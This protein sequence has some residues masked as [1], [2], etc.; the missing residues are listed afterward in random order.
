MAANLTGQVRNIAEV[1][2]AVAK[3]DLSKKITVDVKGELLELKSTINTMVDQLN[4][5]ASEVSRVAKEVGTEGK[6]G[7]QARVP[8]V[9]GTWK[10]LTD[11]VNAMAGNL[12]GQV[13]NIAEVTTAVAKGDL[14]KKITV[15]VRG[16]I[17][18][19]KSTFNTMVDQLNA[20]ASEVSRVA[21]E[22]GTEGKLGGQA[23]VVGVGGTWKDLTDNVNFMAA[24]LTGQ[25]R[26]IAEVTTAVAKGDLSKKITVDVKGELLE[27]KSTVNTMVDQLNAFASEVSRVAR[28]VGT[29]GKLGGQARVP[30]V[31]G[32]WKDLTDNVNAMAANVTGQVRNIAEVTTAVA[33][34]DLSKKITVDVKG[35]I[36]ELKSTMNTMVDQ[37]N[38]FASEVS[39]VAREVGSEGKLGG[40]A[41]VTG[42]GGTWKDLTDNVNAMAANLTGQVRNI[43]EVTTAV[44]RGDLSKKITVD[45]RGEIL[46]LKSTF[47][48]MV[49]QLNAFA[50][51]V[52]RVA[53]E[54]GSE[55]RLGGQAEVKGVAGV[56]KGLTDNVNAMAAN[57][58][59]QVR[60][61]AE[62]TTAV[63][64]GDLSKKITVDVRGEILELKNTINRMVDQLNAFAGEVS[65]VAREVGSEGKLGG[66]AQVSGVGGVWKDLT[67]NVN[68]MAANLTGQVRNIAEV[69]TAV[70]KGDLSKK[71]TVD[72]RGEI[73]EL[74]STINT[75]VDQLN[76]F[77]G[78]VSRVA[79]EVGTE[80][81]LGG[82]A[83][84]TGVG[85]T[86]KDLTDNVNFM[87][88]NLTNQVRGIAQVVTAVARGDLKR[89]V[90]FEAKGEIAALSD[91]I[92]G[93]ID[94]LATFADQVTNVA[95]EV[96]I[97]GKLGGQAKV[98]GAAGLWRDLTDNVNQLAANL[99]DQVRAIAEVA[100]AVTKGDL[101]RSVTVEAQ[102][103][104][105]VLKDNI[106]EMIR[107]LKD[108]TL[109]NTEQDWL[110]TNLAKFTRMVQGHRDLFAVSRLVLS[111]LAP[112]VHA[113]QG[114][115]YMRTTRGSEPCL[116]LLASYAH[117]PTK[118]LPRILR[119]G[120][121]LV[122]QCAYE[123]KRILLD[124]LPHDYVRI[125]SVLGSAKPMSVIVLPVLFEGQVKAVIEL[126]SIRQF[127]DTHLSF[128]DQL[129]EGIGIVFN[130]IEANMRTEDLLKQSQSLTT[131]LQSQ[132]E[133][134]KKTNDR[135]EQQ[136]DNLQK[137]ESLLMK[138]QGELQGANEELQE[139]ASMLS[140]QM[141]E[142]A[143]KNAEVE[144]AKAALEEKAEQLALSSRYKSE[145]LANMSHEIRTPLNSLLILARML[146]DNPEN[147]LS[148]KQIEYART[149]HAA[150][151][152]LLS[153]INDILDLAKVESG[154]VT[155]NIGTEHFSELCE[156]VDRT[157][158]QI[159]HDKGL[160]F[161]V[162][163][164][165]SLPP[166]LQTDIKRLQQILKNL[167][168]N[169]CK[170][171]ERGEVSLR[172]APARTGWTPGNPA[173]DDA[174]DVVA[175]AVVDTGVGI[176]EHKQRIIFEAFQQADGT[177][178]RQY[179]G[180]GLG[181]SISREL[182]RLLG[183]ELRVS[184]A[185]GKGSTFTLYLPL[186]HVPQLEDRPSEQEARQPAP[187]PTGAAGT[188]AGKPG[189]L[190]AQPAVED[191]RNEVQAGDRVVLIIEDDVRFAGVLLELARENGFKAVVA[192][193]A[194]GGVEL[195]KELLP[196]AILLDLKLPDMDGWAVLDLLKHD[197]Q[198][199]HIPV[200]VI[201]VDEGLQK[202]FHMGA[203]GATQKPVTKETLEDV[204]AKTREFIDR[205]VKT[206]LI[207][208]SD[209]SQRQ[210]LAGALA[211]VEVVAAS[212]GREVLAI[213][214]RDR[215]DCLMMGPTLT[216]MSAVE[217]LKRISRLDQAA[218]VP[219]VMQA[220]SGFSRGDQDNLRRL[221][222][223]IV[224]KQVTT[225]EAVLEETTLFLHQALERLPKAQRGALV[226]RQ[227]SGTELSGKK[228]L[229]V[230]DDIRNIF[231]LTG[232]L[233]QH[234]VCV[235]NAENGTDGIE[236]LKE[237]SD[238]DIVLMD[239]MMPE[240]DG[241]DTIRII[242]GLEAFKTLP[243]IAI[244]ARA[245]KGDRE[246]CIEAGASDYIAK[247]INMEQLTSLMRV[248]LNRQ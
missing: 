14:S 170:F 113:Q 3:G 33:K 31:A 144:L 232:A 78:E 87:A 162:V 178:S 205:E 223:L 125:G 88:A 114:I 196:D 235:I 63:A 188:P 185:P 177:T 214:E 108:T 61:I 102:G 131:E 48:T 207:A 97:E 74:K 217:L 192:L 122:G 68:F 241:Y 9:A 127:S 159:A 79:R 133:E 176:A 182:T 168:S 93:M 104:V 171:T 158:R 173:L 49:D 219:I 211:G 212:S 200:N 84:V 83:Q 226:Q 53:R 45:V 228:A 181:L 128:L 186:S 43:A 22:V 139:K 187:P 206:L 80:G 40:Q 199:R 34:G 213:L 197:P 164:D 138:Q 47:N 70:A 96:G 225:P 115:L 110:K 120:E 132:Q 112:L 154:T 149:I 24:N 119:M 165:H 140:E 121:G 64:T 42:V 248:W 145:F 209:A 167:L 39:R 86:W 237:N 50:G 239:I 156:Y 242:R 123:K 155:L 94:T 118:N 51:E 101:T 21:R 4:A 204:L 46:E 129:T 82:Q 41:Q 1:T 227:I 195:V 175:F 236:M 191:D 163:L 137:S 152:D 2:T 28:E 35:E 18:E 85:G 56:W 160:S 5:F 81:K 16:E 180:T 25:V 124:D 216:D 23:Q 116:E 179:G 143:Y 230:D 44:A 161:S 190:H 59:G 146:S 234:G 157:F 243:I 13:R 193:N 57:L 135:L 19:L 72:V 66:Q 17:L 150:G 91:T 111:E 244:T 233:E 58:T 246:K 8:G 7:G 71:I 201:S 75:M 117:K 148:V 215:V 183:G 106:N 27:L 73:L 189:S 231:A 36:L 89:K 99:T 220:G 105:A 245:M 52:S 202:C 20:F 126:A 247:P 90:V 38:A 10:D 238:T 62:V 229:I 134:L 65:R 30:G 11:N 151:I 141:K 194:A 172:I 55:G 92:N 240:L 147:N 54:V 221:S 203:L 107:N 12:T 32:T 222:E 98:P 26:N 142:V 184:S 6:L 77:A 37:L 15:D 109:K 153:L 100:T 174:D 210:E 29:E 60:N 130:T 76:A 224:L 198:T 69:T 166:A 218:A 95:R 169:A 67:E 208:S 103:E 136:A